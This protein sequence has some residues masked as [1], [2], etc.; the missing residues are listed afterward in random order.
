MVELLVQP[1][2]TGFYVSVNPCLPEVRKH[3]T[4]IC[5]EIVADYEVDGLHLDYIR[6]PNEHP[7]LHGHQY[8]RDQRTLEL[9]KEATGLGP[10][11]KPSVWDQWRCDCVTALLRDIRRTAKSLRP[12]L[13]LS[14]AVAVDR[15]EAL[16]R[17]QVT[18]L[19]HSELFPMHK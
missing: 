7:V 18:I 12:Q 14:A 4:G 16:S 15:K 8:P 3:I 13:V 6:F 9:F 19:L 11:D 17:F 1:L 2:N 10:E 5:Q